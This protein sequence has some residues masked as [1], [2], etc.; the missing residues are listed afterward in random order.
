M[1]DETLRCPHCGGPTET[2]DKV[3]LMRKS[4]R[5]RDWSGDVLTREKLL[6]CL[7]CGRKFSEQHA[8]SVP[9]VTDVRCVRCGTPDVSRRWGVVIVRNS[10]E[11]RDIDPNEPAYECDACGKL[12]S[13]RHYMWARESGELAPPAG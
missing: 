4:Q 12:F 7:A 3:T 13:E 9:A 10:K 11:G 6:H 1:T 8:A 5:G 2:G